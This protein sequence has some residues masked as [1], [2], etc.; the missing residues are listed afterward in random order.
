MKEIIGAVKLG[1]TGDKLHP[2]YKEIYDNGMSFFNIC[3]KCAGTQ[4]GRAQITG[5]FKGAQA[6]CRVES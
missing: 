3:C 2:A 1:R 4:S 6:T 5:F